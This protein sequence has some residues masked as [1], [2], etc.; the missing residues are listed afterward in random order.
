MTRLLE[1]DPGGGEIRIH[2]RYDPDL[3]S[4]VRSLPGR[5]WNAEGRYWSVPPA[6]LAEAARRLLPLGFVLSEE[7]AQALESEPGGTGF[8]DRDPAATDESE[9]RDPPTWTVSQLNE[10]VRSALLDAFPLPFWISGEVL[11]YDRNA[12]KKHVYFQLAE[13]SP[14]AGERPRAV[15][16]AVLFAGARDAIERR[17]A[18]ATER[19]ALADGVQVRV[20]A[21]VDLYP[22][23][24]SYQVI[25]EDIDPEFTLGELAR[26]RERILAE[27][28]RLGLRERNLG[29][30][31]PRPCLA[32]G[33]I[34]SYQSD[35]Y[36]DVINEL[37]RSGYSFRV[38]ALDIHVQGREMEAELLAALAWF[39]R[40]AARYDVL[41]IV[42]G[43]GAR[44]EL[45]DFDTLPIALAVAK[46]PLK[47]VIGIGHHRDRGVLDFIAHSE[48]T[49]TAA[50][51][52]LV[53]LAETEAAHVAR[54]AERIAA[55]ATRAVEG[56]RAQLER[57]AL[58]VRRS[59]EL[60]LERRR[61]QVETRRERL[62]RGALD[63]V[64]AARERLGAQAALVRAADPR[65]VLERGYAWLRDARGRSVTRARGA[66][67]GDALD[68][69]LSDGHLALRV[70]AAKLTDMPSAGA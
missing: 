26:R 50:A 20:L 16:T 35:A 9:P 21:R 28:E 17:L 14:D 11:G 52:H 47:V 12:H 18:A 62:L 24:G 7:L 70:E 48:K 61:F 39:E 36:N 31:F 55:L 49:P 25:I 58:L 54:T 37:T 22:A 68:A 3:V 63:A 41:V 45:M 8:A 1:R 59:L 6:N 19:I 27:L 57:T 32:V 2:F 44:T 42:R 4:V 34:T 67:P 15:V 66:A 69:Q 23:T 43:G 65:R 56:A 5:K 33:L 40:H 38:D 29:L 10:Q 53:T 46:H 51:R 13:K 64:T 30:G 60:A